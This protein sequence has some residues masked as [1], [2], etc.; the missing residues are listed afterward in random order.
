MVTWS[1]FGQD[2]DGWGV[3]A[4]K[5][6]VDGT[7][8]T[9]EFRVNTQTAGDQMASQVSG[10]RWGDFYFVWS[11]FGQDGDG[12]GVF[13]QYYTFNDK[14]EGAERQINTH[15]AGDQR[16]PA[17]AFDSEGNWLVVWESPGQDGSGNGIYADWYKYTGR[18]GNPSG[19]FG[20]NSTTSLDQ[21]APAVSRN[22]ARDFVVVWMS[23]G[24]DGDAASDTNVYGQL[25]DGRA[26]GVTRFSSEFRVNTT[27]SGDQEIPAVAMSDTG[28]YLIAWSGNGVGDA[29]GVFA[30]RYADSFGSVP[31]VVGLADTDLVYTENDPPVLIDGALTITPGDN[32]DLLGAQVWFLAGFAPF[33]DVLAFTDQLGISGS[34]D[35]ATGV[36]TLTGTAPVS[37]YQTALRTVTYQHT[38]DSP[39]GTIRMLEVAVDDGTH[40]A[41]DRRNITI[42]PVND[43]PAITSDGGGPSA[44]IVVVENTT[45]VTTVTATDVDLP[46]QPV[47]YALTGGA[48]A[49]RFAIDGTTGVL[50]FTT[51]PDFELPADADGNNVYELQVTAGD[52]SGGQDVQTI[53][54]AV[55]DDDEFNVGPISDTDPAAETVAESAAV[56]TAVGITAYASDADG[57]ARHLFAG[58]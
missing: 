58:G 32:A 50:T 28:G 44:S 18:G 16:A 45:S 15:T 37:D 27:R 49:G 6:A 5:F 23:A 34:Y 20:V 54:I 42:A 48:D 13:G 56:G 33:Q 29:E 14:F 41:T 46:A 31:P 38:S 12:W 39:D 4:R 2:G 30:Q 47:T 43:P 10:D 24:Q 19:E 35:P 57:T 3:Y 8:L 55:A 26:S 25:F 40:L 17:V 52:G 1:S 51:G 7:P 36:L 11:S 53:T 22:G 21:S 9:S